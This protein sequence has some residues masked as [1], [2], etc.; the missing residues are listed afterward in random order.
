MNSYKMVNDFYLLV[1]LCLK[2]T[3][4][5]SSFK[6]FKNRFYQLQGEGDFVGVCVCV[7]YTNF[8]KSLPIEN[9]KY[10]RAGIF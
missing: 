10:L 6:T 7:T 3:V 4:N 1:T 9:F 8:K 2:F 5:I